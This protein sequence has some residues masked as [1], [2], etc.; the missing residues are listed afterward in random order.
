MMNQEFVEWL[1]SD[2]KEVFPISDGFCTHLFMRVSKR[3]GIDY[4]YDQQEF[5]GDTTP[6]IRP[7]EFAGI[8]NHKDGLIYDGSDVLDDTAAE[9]SK[10][11]LV[12]A[13]QESVRKNIESRVGNDRRNLKVQELTDKNTIVSLKTYSDFEKANVRR[14]YLNGENPERDQ[15]KWNYNIGLRTE[16]ELLDYIEDPEKYV[17]CV[18]ETYWQD[19]R[20]H[21]EMLRDFLVHDTVVEEYKKLVE[22]VGNPVHII[23]RII[24]AVT[25]GNPRTVTVTICKNGQECTFKMDASVLRRDCK[26]TY[27]VQYIVAADRRKY[28]QQF[29]SYGYSPDEIVRITYKG[30][31]LYEANA[32]VTQTNA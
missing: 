30:K 23:R 2:S 15:F 20:N 31:V 28:K 22:D 18:A 19:E 1:K 27:G 13:F 32:N 24:E 12:I 7:F 16:N 25:S 26:H 17:Q 14:M 11:C 29:G 10:A 3:P 5:H 4:L 8:Y 6:H 9:R 21:E